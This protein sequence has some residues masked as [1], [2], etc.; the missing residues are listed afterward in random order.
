M[1]ENLTDVVLI[2]ISSYFIGSISFAY[3]FTKAM[4]GKDIR[5]I[6]SGN[7][8]TTNTFRAIG[9]MALVVMLLDLAKGYVAASIGLAVMGEIGA[10]IACVVA[11]LGHTFS[12]MLGFKGGKGVATAGGAFIAMAPYIFV[13]LLAIEII[14]SFGTGY[15]SVGSIACAIAVPILAFAFDEPTIYKVAF[16]SMAAIVFIL[17]RGNLKR[18][19]N[20]T[21]AKTFGK[22]K[23]KK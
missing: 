20:G 22:K 21:E 9:K 7:A 3:I 16:T 1:F 5:D 14:F 4:T 18:L 2:I 13:I 8:G 10:V 23:S 11:V 17:H 15:V 19:L 6:G 12:I